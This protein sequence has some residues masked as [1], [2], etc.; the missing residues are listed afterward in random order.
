M[1]DAE[2]VVSHTLLSRPLTMK[3]DRDFLSRAQSGHNPAAERALAIRIRDAYNKQYRQNVRFLPWNGTRI[4]ETAQSQ[5]QPQ[6]CGCDCAGCDDQGRHCH[7]ADKDC[8]L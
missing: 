3:V 2:I 8:Y 1:S 6:G 7:K 4:E 5:Q